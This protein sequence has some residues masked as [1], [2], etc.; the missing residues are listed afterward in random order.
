MIDILDWFDINNPA[1]LQAC[2]HFMNTGKWPEGFIP[3]NVS[4]SRTWQFGLMTL[5]AKA[6]MDEHA[7]KIAK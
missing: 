3:Q 5:L 2:R 4:L 6:Y 7:P 1:H